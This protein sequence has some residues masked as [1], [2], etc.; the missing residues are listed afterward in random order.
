MANDAARE[1]R[2]AASCNVSEDGAATL[3][4]SVCFAAPDRIWMVPLRLHVG[5][6]VMDA[7]EASRLTQQVNDHNLAQAAV[8]IF[9]KRVARTR[10]LADGDRVE[11]YRTLTFDPKDSR[12]RRAQ[13]RQRFRRIDSDA[14]ARRVARS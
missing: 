11:I 4:V 10:K 2:S 13:H 9:G 7:I 5:S 1:E 14:I 12:R 8:G 6:N 3:S